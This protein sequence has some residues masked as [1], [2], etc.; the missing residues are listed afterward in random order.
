MWGVGCVCGGGGWGGVC[1]FIFVYN[2]I[3]TVQ[4]NI[5]II[6]YVLSGV[7]LH[8]KIFMLMSL[9]IQTPMY[10]VMCY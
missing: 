8:M 6:L 10:Y 9:R 2:H 3:F 7:V 1:M 5:C 4:V